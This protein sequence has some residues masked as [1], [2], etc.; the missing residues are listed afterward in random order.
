M[1]K[2]IKNIITKRRLNKISKLIAED[3]I[4]YPKGVWSG[5][6]G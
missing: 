2:L 6:R 4:N 3:F 5:E 1:I